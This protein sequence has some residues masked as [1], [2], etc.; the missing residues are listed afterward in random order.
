LIKN[1]KQVAEINRAGLNIN[2]E[3]QFE[4]CK[5]DKIFASKKILSESQSFLK[6]SCDWCRQQLIRREL[7]KGS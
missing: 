1:L 2:V 5:P 3:S 6:K 7:E 4:I